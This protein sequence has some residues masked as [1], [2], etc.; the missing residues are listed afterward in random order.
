MPQYDPETRDLLMVL[1]FC[2]SKIVLLL[3]FSGPL[4]PEQQF[5]TDDISTPLFSIASGR[6]AGES[7]ARGLRCI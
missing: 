1:D 3:Y 6:F 5:G 7:G 2:L 4:I